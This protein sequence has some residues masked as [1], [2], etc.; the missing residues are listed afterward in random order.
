MADAV[1]PITA[2][3]AAGLGATCLQSIATAVWPELSAYGVTGPSLVWGLAGGYAGE[4]L[5]R[6]K[7][8]EEKRPH[9]KLALPALM[10]S[11][12]IGA[13]AGN[14]AAKTWFSGGIEATAGLSA[15][16]GATWQWLILAWMPA[17]I[18]AGKALIGKWAS[19]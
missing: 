2:C 16:F 7:A 4:M 12:G 18:D 15:F 10:L 9:T 6:Q 5:R 11:A 19:K 14:W 13:L 1:T 8:A 17:I 3:V